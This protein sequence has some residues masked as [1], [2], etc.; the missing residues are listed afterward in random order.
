MKANAGQLGRALDAPPADVRLFFVYGPDEAGCLAYA[1][2]LEKAMG[3]G[4]ERIDL[5]GPT[6]KGDPAR[7]A[8]EAASF[9]MFGD[10]RW[11]RVSQAGEESLP[12]IEAL[13]EA[14][15]AGN[16]VIAIGG[17]LKN[18]AKIV[19]LCLD[20]PAVL[21]LACYVPDEREATQIAS[22][23]AQEQGLRLPGPLARRIAELTGGDRALMAGEVEKLVLY[24]DAAPDRPREVNEETLD[25]LSAQALEA[26]PGPLV[27]AVMEGDIPTLN[28][29][30]AMLGQ[31]GAALASVLRPILNRAMLLAA[32]RAEWDKGG[33]LDGAMD[34]AGRGIFWKEKPAVQ[35][36]VK[37]WN[38]PAIA[39][40]IHR[41]S[42]AERATRDSRGPGELVAR[43]ELL[44]IARQAARDR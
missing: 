5:D 18:S 25:A 42:A 13:L 17:A 7:L 10:K 14:P 39:R 36:Q 19:K 23:M 16:P 12:A 3:A 38:A 32:I 15:Q 4:A 27:N 43:H 11:V 41:L 44:T 24:L 26:D 33:Q 29:E 8:D 1:V 22:A 34:K 37:R 20:H 31:R 28:A 9:S 6:L 40:A 35:R 2:R 30:L 21:T